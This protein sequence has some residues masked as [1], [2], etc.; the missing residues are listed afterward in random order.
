MIHSNSSTNKK[1]Y[2]LQNTSGVS[3]GMDTSSIL[4]LRRKSKKG[5]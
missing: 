5:P 2:S 1:N 3:P 4:N